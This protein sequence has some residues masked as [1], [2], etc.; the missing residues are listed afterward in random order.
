LVFFLFVALPATVERGP[1]RSG[2]I[3]GLDVDA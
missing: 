1:I 2:H 3:I